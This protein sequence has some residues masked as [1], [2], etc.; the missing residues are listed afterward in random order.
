LQSREGACAA[1]AC[2]SL[3]R[4]TAQRQAPT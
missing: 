2:G 1:A 3:E 4:C